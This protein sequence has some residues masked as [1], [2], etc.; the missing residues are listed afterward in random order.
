M[1]VGR[2]G[3]VNSAEATI[4]SETFHH[5]F[6]DAE[7]KTDVLGEVWCEIEVEFDAEYVDN[8]IGWYEFWGTDYRDVQME[9]QV[10]KVHVMK[11]S[12]Y[13][14]DDEIWREWEW[15]TVGPFTQAMQE[16]IDAA[17][18][19]AENDDERLCEIANDR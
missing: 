9:Y 15:S 18:D 7:L 13:E 12:F 16:V 10:G 3:Q 5:T 19:F 11:V 1:H 6:D 2:V 14:G 17:Q 8:G 4:M